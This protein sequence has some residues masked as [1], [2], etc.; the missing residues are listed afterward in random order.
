MTARRPLE[1]LRVVELGEL[2]AGPFIGTLLGEFGAE[3]IK[4]ERPGRGDVLRQF[5]PAH[6]GQSL[7]WLANARNK[8]SVVLDLS[9]P[10]ARGALTDLLRQSDILLDSLRPGTL[11]GWEL[12]DEEL[13]RLNPRLIVV[14]VSAFGRSGPYRGRG[15]YDPVAQGFSGLSYVTGDADGPP[16]R[17]GGAIPVCDFMS[18]VLGAFGALLAAYDRDARAHGRGQ[19]IDVALYDMAFR[20]LAPLLTLYELTGEVWSRQGNRSLGGAP[21]GHFR[22]GDDEWVCVSVQND[23]QF[24]RCADLVERPDWKEDLRY[25]SLESRTVHRHAI[26]TVVHTWISARPRSAVLAAFDAA[27]LAAGP[28]NSMADLAQDKHLASRSVIREELPGIGTL[29]TPTPVPFLS[30]TP[31]QTATPAPELGEHTEEVLRRVLGYADID[32]SRLA[33]EQKNRWPG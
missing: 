19:V 13:E 12:G 3:I 25:R 7:Y 26:E 10:L 24:A 5:G 30:R 22:A 14:H 16:M 17:A 8:K 18:G 15:G 6:N 9:R 4:V 2:I 1:G 32:L 21:T 31:G 29:R 27:G 28:V 23:E 11:D 33:R 20:M